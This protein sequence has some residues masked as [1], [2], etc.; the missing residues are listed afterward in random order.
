[1][2]G[3]RTS[4]RA[5]LDSRGTES[6]QTTSLY[7]DLAWIGPRYREFSGSLSSSPL[8]QSLDWTTLRRSTREMGTAA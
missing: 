3:R 5:G 4:L 2:R 7:A 6:L 1:M 8:S